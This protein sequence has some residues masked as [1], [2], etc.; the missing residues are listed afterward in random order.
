M[1]RYFKQNN[2]ACPQCLQ[3]SCCRRGFTRTLKP[4]VSGFT[5][6]ETLIAISIFSMTIVTMMSVLGSGI[7]DTNYAKT[8]IEAEYLAQEG[9]EYVRNMRDNYV[10]YTDA[11]GLTWDSFVL[12]NKAYPSP[13]SNFTRTIQMIPTTN[14]KEVKISCTVS[15]VQ[16]SGPHQVIF[17]EN[18]FDWT[19]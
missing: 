3:H 4:L 10:L 9:I 5:L 13:Y 14:P 12:A 7:S 8:K 1:K 6:V 19:E 18:L 17:S 15:W 2:K 16:G 11:T